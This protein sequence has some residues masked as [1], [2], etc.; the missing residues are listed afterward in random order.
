MNVSSISG[1]AMSLAG[2]G[3]A[4]GSALPLGKVAKNMVAFQILDAFL[5]AQG[6]RISHESGCGSRSSSAATI[7]GLSNTGGTQR[8]SKL[9]MDALALSTFMA[10]A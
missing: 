3:S 8:A 6:Q 10:V 1:M 4:S 9:I 7:Y 2:T 5:D